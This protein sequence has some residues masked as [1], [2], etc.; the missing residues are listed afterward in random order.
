MNVQVARVAIALIAVIIVGV[1]VAN[2]AGVAGLAL[3]TSEKPKL[4]VDLTV[5]TN[6]SSGFE[7]ALEIHL[8][9]LPK[10][11][12]NLTSVV[13]AWGDGV[14]TTFH[15]HNPVT[16]YFTMTR[17]H[18]YTSSGT[19]SVGATANAQIG[20]GSLAKKYTA[21]ATA[22]SVTVPF[23]GQGGGCPA[24]GCP[25]VTSLFTY[26]TSGLAV[27][28]T[29]Q[30][31][32]LNASVTSVAWTFGDGTSGTGGSDSHTYAAAGTFLVTE[33][34]TAS[35]PSP[36]TDTVTST[37][38]Q[39]VTV[40]TGGSGGGGTAST[41]ATPVVGLSVLSGLLIGSGVGLLLA[42]AVWKMPE[43]AIAF[44]ASLG[45]GALVG[46]LAAAGML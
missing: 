27:T 23:G 17:D 11:T 1:G 36:S 45:V 41:G 9:V 3:T 6:A 15:P 33:T 24:T 13:V 10:G 31:V 8:A 42:V 32:A 2:A 35:A 40:S 18:N 19:F 29:D 38:S 26:S 14:S 16:G 22:I 7:A 34:V 12:M 20:N 28:V 43:S 46:A 5:S 39:N 30:S 44:L 37:S 21:T 4:H 25:E